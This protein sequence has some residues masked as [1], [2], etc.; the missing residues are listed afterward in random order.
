LLL[1]LSF[2][3]FFPFSFSSLF[4]SL[5]WKILTDVWRASSFAERSRE[6]GDSRRDYATGEK[7]RRQP[8]Q[9]IRCVIAREKVNGRS[10]GEKTSFRNMA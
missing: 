5:C 7:K 6:F 1:S 8:E 10:D 3:F 9:K 2:S 4:F